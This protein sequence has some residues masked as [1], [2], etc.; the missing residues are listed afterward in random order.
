MFPIADPEPSCTQ[1]NLII[2]S[3][4]Y[5]LVKNFNECDEVMKTKAEYRETVDIVLTVVGS[6][7]TSFSSQSRPLWE[8]GSFVFVVMLWNLKLVCRLT[9][10]PVISAY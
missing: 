6:E 7:P 1:H 5:F 2:C 3:V 9:G 8:Q 10:L 4:C